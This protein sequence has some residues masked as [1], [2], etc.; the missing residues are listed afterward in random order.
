[1]LFSGTII[2]NLRWG[3]EEATREEIYEAARA[4]EAHEFI[5]S[6]PLGYET[7]LGQGG[8]NLSGGQKQ[9]ISIARALLRKPRI[10]VLD[11]C[12][13]AVDVATEVR[14]REAIKSLSK[15]LTTITI[16][17][18][19]TSVMDA[20]KIIVMDNGEIDSIGTHEELLK[21]CEVYKDIFLSQIGKEGI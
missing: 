8:V 17:Q 15:N 20:D 13:S 9:R 12:T 6:F 2:D 10:L 1:M 7:I 16:A 11:D 4:S 5:S 21:S 14:I 19:I 3:R 18:R